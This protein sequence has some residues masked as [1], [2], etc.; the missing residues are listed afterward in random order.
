[1]SA[2]LFANLSFFYLFV[3]F[4]FFRNGGFESKNDGAARIEVIFFSGQYAY[5]I[6]SAVSGENRQEYLK[7]LPN[8]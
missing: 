6:S 8:F 1:M 5:C 7:L 3:C 4:L 2:C